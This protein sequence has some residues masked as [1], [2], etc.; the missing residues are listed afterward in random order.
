MQVRV[1]AGEADQPLDD[2]RG[3]GDDELAPLP[4]Q[5]L[6]CPYKYRKAAAVHKTKR[7]KIHHE[8][9]RGATQGAAEGKAQPVSVAHVKFAPQPQYR[10]FPTVV[11]GDGQVGGGGHRVPFRE[12]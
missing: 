2:G 1:E 11:G 10:P 5:Q 7:G 8:E 6:V 4:G 9:L 12:A 3:T